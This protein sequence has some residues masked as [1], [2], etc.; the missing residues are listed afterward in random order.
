MSDN[1]LEKLKNGMLTEIAIS[2]F[3]ISIL[4]EIAGTYV[5]GKAFENACPYY[6]LY[7]LI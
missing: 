5:I 1:K 4:S 2:V 3:P 7:I 6:K